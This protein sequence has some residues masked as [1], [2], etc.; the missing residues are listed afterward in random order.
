MN[1]LFRLKDSVVQFLSPQAKRRRTLPVTPSSNNEQEHRFLSPISEI[2]DKKRQIAALSRLNQ[3]YLSPSDTKN[4]RKRTRDD[5]EEDAQ[6]DEVGVTPDDSVS[7]SSPRQARRAARQRQARQ[8]ESAGS[9]SEAIEEASVELV[10]EDE[11]AQISPDAKVQE[12]LAR[13]A[14][15]ASRLD[16]IEKV[17]STGGFHPHELFLYE[18]ISMRSFEELFPL[19]W[20][21]DFPTL[22][23]ALFTT[24]PS[25]QFINFNHKPSSHGMLCNISNDTA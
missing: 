9:R 2:Q 16:D 6:S 21:I 19:E 15:L 14:E 10:E 5:F 3:K 25:K 11:E 12:Y 18:R 1:Q 13:Q 7:Q 23:P 4:L 8:E 22:P 24:E 20:H 17:R